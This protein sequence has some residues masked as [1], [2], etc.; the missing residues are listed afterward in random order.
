MAELF[1]KVCG[2]TR[3]EDAEAAAAAGASAVGINFWPGSKRFVADLGRAAELAAAARGALV[4]GVFVDAPGEA[5]DRVLGHVPLDRVQLHGDEP[6]A[7][8]AALGQRLLRVVRVFGEADLERVAF[9]PGDPVLVDAGVAG[10]GG[11]GARLPLELCRRAAALRRVILAGGL[12]PDNVAGVV[13]HARPFGVDVATG[14][15]RAPGVKDAD[16]IRAF[17]ANARGRSLSPS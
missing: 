4:V 6:D 15:E 1:V 11:Q 7:L 2:V 10:Y 17:V 12:D 5:I 8:C 3:P 13:E 14:V 16:K 9:A